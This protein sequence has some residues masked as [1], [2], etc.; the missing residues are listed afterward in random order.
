MATNKL[1]IQNSS[2]NVGIGTTVP[3]GKFQISDSSSPQTRLHFSGSASSGNKGSLIFSH[4]RNSDGTQELLGY[5][6]GVA[7]D[8][9]SAGGIRFISRNNIDVE[10]FRITS[11]GRLG[12]GTTN[13]ASKLSIIEGAGDTGKSFE[14]Y[15]GSGP[16]RPFT[17]GINRN[18]G[19]AWIG[20][21]AYQ[22][23]ADAQ[24]YAVSNYAAAIKSGNGLI[25]QVAASGTGGNTISWTDALQ[26]TSVGNVGI[27]TSSPVGKLTV[28]ANS[29]SRNKLIILNDSS[30]SSSQV[31]LVVNAYGNSW[32]IGIGAAANNSNAFYINEDS[33]DANI[34]RLTIKVGGNVGIGTTNPSYKLTI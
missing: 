9:Q 28:Y 3:A 4:N 13:P 14:L 19:D 25:F 21:N 23:T 17:M 11:S 16:N 30:S 24:T 31:E 22:S 8:N 12:I 27:N 5:I 7:E 2:G 34:N 20:W 18:N 10:T 33:N 6:Q 29:N 15:Y 1:I 32:G 26:I